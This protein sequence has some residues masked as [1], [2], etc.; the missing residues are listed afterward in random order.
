MRAK[1]S[2]DVLFLDQTL[3]RDSA[4]FAN[5]LHQ[6]FATGLE[7]PGLPVE[8]IL[9]GS[10]GLLEPNFQFV[11]EILQHRAI[12]NAKKRDNAVALPQWFARDSE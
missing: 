4:G 1:L 11:G 2:I 6:A 12:R 5:Q 9:P 8:V 10:T 7:T 3:R